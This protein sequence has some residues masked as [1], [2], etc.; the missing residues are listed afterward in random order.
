[1]TTKM[2]VEKIKHLLSLNYSLE[3]ILELDTDQLNEY[4]EA[5]NLQSKFNVITQE[6]FNLDTGLINERRDDIENQKMADCNKL[7]PTS[8]HQKDLGAALVD[9]LTEYNILSRTDDSDYCECCSCDDYTEEC[10]YNEESSYIDMLQ[11]TIYTL[12]ESVK[13]YKNTLSSVLPTDNDYA[14]YHEQYSNVALSLPKGMDVW[15]TI[16]YIADNNDIIISLDAIPDGLHT[17]AATITTDMIQH[18]PKIPAH[19]NV[20][21]VY[22]IY[23]P[24]F[25][26]SAFSQIYSKFSNN[27][28]QVFVL[29]S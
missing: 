9:L 25:N 20:G 29:V 21:N 28:D 6:E 11:D 10:E 3:E 15:E 26:K 2:D 16:A 4:Q 13:S 24:G 14:E 17:D 7:M 23:T 5:I 8:N 1:M 18:I 22:V 19:I 27:A 12:I